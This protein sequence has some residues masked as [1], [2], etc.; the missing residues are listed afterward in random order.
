MATKGYPGDYGKGSIIKGL[1]AAAQ[2]KAFQEIFHAGTK[3]WM[4]A[5]SPAAGACWP[6][7]PM[8]KTVSEARERAYRAVDLID[9]PE[10]SC[11][12]DIGWREVERS[13]VVV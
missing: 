11:R 4:A 6:S 1:E 8:G 12:R 9:W 5:S 2:A 10:G 13:G 7:A 3:S